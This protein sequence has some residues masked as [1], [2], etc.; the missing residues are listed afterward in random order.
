[1]P[2][3]N[4]VDPEGNICF[5]PAKGT[6][7]GN[8]GCLHDKNK[9]IISQSRNDA[10]IICVLDYQ[11]VKRTLMT[12]GSYTELFFLDEA[13]ALA[14][15]HR[16]CFTCRR[17]NYKKFMKSWS[18]GNRSGVKVLAKEVDEELKVERVPSARFETSSLAGL[19]DGVM[20]KSKANGAIFLI[21]GDSLYPWSFN[22]YSAATSASAEL[23]PF[24]VLTPTSTIKAMHHGYEVM[25]HSS[26]L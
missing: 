2:L 22:G 3:Q 25:L 8:R 7:M 26:A 4:R 21:R 12:P 14:A 11:A 20:V 24:V 9:R 6:L 1:M 17:E 23:G 10:W 16:P 5:S 15:G 18:F 13:T 19:P